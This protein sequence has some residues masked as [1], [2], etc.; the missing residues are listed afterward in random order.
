MY[1]KGIGL[2]VNSLFLMSSPS[3]LSDVP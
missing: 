3:R 2:K 1:F